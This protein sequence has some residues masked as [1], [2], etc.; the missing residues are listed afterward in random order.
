MIPS[1]VFTPGH[2]PLDKKNVYAD[3][4]DPQIRFNDS[5]SRGFVP[6]IYGNYGVGKSTMVLFCTKRWKDAGKQ[7]YIESA[8]GKNMGDVFKAILE[9]LSYEVTTV[10]LTEKENDS[11]SQV[12]S[13]GEATFWGV[14][15]ATVSGQIFRKQKKKLA[16]TRTLL[17]SNPTDSKVIELADKNALC[18]IIDEL[19]R[20]DANFVREISLFV[21]AVKNSDRKNFKICLLGT[22]LDASKLTMADPGIERIIQ[23]IKI[24]QMTRTE[25]L[26]IV[27][28][29]MQKLGLSLDDEVKE[30]VIKT[31]VG[32][33]YIVQYICLVAAEKAVKENILIVSK[34]DVQDALISYAKSK[35]QRMI[36]AYKS[37]IET[38]GE[39][40][41]RKQILHAMAKSEDEYVS[42]D[43]IVEKASAAIGD[44]VESQSLSG[45]LRELK[46]DKY[47]SIL[48]DIPNYSGDG[49]IY[50]QSF[51][52]DPAMRTIIR[53]IDEVGIEGLELE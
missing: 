26:Q 50:N 3:R 22:S 32:S 9:K 47:G 45:P 14:L 44:K 52:S 23:E 43:Y 53:M 6:L 5:L 51:F 21:K 24:G 11:G 46:S 12:G 29:G 17:V 49:R 34:K 4:G 39:K 13:S 48:S 40:R 28:P 33:P 41:Y 30:K 7:V 18:L 15:K 38:V 27:D 2:F 19:H 1:E 37:S 35:A 31:C 16:E 10:R 36:R 25:V 8:Y 20:A 42:M